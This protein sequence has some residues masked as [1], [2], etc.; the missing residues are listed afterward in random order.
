MAVEKKLRRAALD[1]FAEVLELFLVALLN[2]VD[3]QLQPD[4]WSRRTESY[5]RGLDVLSGAARGSGI[6]ERLLGILRAGRSAAASGD[7]GS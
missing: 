2:R 7:H 4:G 1:Q 5:L 3:V 6:S